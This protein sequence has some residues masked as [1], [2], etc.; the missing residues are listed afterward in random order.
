MVCVIISAPICLRSAIKTD[1]KKEKKTSVVSADKT[2]KNMS[3][4]IK[5]QANNAKTDVGSNPTSS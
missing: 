3:M 5:T 1:R 2:K 4:E